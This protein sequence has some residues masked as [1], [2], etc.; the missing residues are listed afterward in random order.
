MFTGLQKRLDI[1]ILVDEGDALAGTGIKYAPLYVSVRFWHCVNLPVCAI[2]GVWLRNSSV[3]STVSLTWG[4][5]LTP[6]LRSAG[7]RAPNMRSQVG[8]ISQISWIQGPSPEVSSWP[9]FSDRLDTEPLTWGL[10]LTH[11]LRSAGYR[12]PNMRSRVDPISHISWIQ[13][14]HRSSQVDPISLINWI[15]SHSP[16]L[17]SWPHFSHQLDTE[18]LSRALKLTRPLSNQLG[19]RPLGA[20]VD[21]CMA[22]EKIPFSVSECWWIRW[23]GGGCR[24][25]RAAGAADLDQCGD[26]HAV[27]QR[28]PSVTS[29]LLCSQSVAVC[30]QRSVVMPLWRWRW[31]LPTPRQSDLQVTHLLLSTQIEVLYSHLLDLQYSTHP[32]EW[33]LLGCYAVWLLKDPT[34]QRR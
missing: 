19:V 5:K 8:P 16:E 10:K 30:Q 6:L 11:F 25:L 32:A 17:W 1:W 2:V 12:A 34:F 9:Y 26:R 18:P 14:P 27:A 4:F 21:P 3:S 23:R 31:F 20:Q 7:Y 28:A 15:Q 13:V 33:C 24:P 22:N 29:W